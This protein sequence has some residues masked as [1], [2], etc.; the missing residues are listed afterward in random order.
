MTL[1]TKFIII[2]GII[3]SPNDISVNTVIS[4]NVDRCIS[5][6][7]FVYWNF[8]LNMQIQTF[9]QDWQKY[10]LSCLVNFKT[11]NWVENPASNQTRSIFKKILAIGR[12]Q[13]CL[14][15]KDKLLLTML[16]AN[17]T[18]Y[19]SSIVLFQFIFYPDSPLRLKQYYLHY[20]ILIKVEFGRIGIY[21]KTKI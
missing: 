9:R 2:S 14:L 13:T 20:L 3:I 5:L 17:R 16:T 11:Y 18:F 21:N 10:T 4:N 12:S 6:H 7:M 1:N 8:I 15:A 19:S